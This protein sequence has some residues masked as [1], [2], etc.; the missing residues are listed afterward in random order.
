MARSYRAKNKRIITRSGNGQFRKSSL[1]DFGIGTCCKCQKSFRIS[2]EH[3]DD[4][5]FPDPREMQ[6]YKTHCPMCGNYEETKPKPEEVI[7][8]KGFFNIE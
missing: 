7:D 4:M 6:F 1:S 8:I 3:F 2:V 5:A